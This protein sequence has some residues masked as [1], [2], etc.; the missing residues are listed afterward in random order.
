[1]SSTQQIL[2]QYWPHSIFSS[3]Q[4]EI[5]DAVLTKQ[6]VLTML[7]LGEEK[8]ICFQV[9]AMLM[10]GVCMVISP[11]SSSVQCQVDKLVGKGI[12]AASLYGALS[13]W[14]T[15]KVLQDVVSGACKF[16]YLPPERLETKLFKAY[17]HRMDCCLIVVN[18]AHSISRMV[19]HFRQP[20]LPIA[21]CRNQLGNVPIIA[22]SV[23]VTPM[24]EADIIGKLQLRNVAVFKKSIESPNIS[25]Y[26]YKTDDK[27]SKA[28]ELLKRFSGNCIIYANRTHVREASW[29]LPTYLP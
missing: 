19:H 6:D 11:F 4:K 7:P 28:L 3:N 23:Y 21:N 5:I 12:T 24:V 17:L 9:P 8:A 29:H 1:M 25:Y 22:I 27:Q 2:Q 13:P 20:Y 18:E 10:Q 16:L 14:E 26:V 15:E